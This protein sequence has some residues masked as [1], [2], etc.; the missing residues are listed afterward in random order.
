MFDPSNLHKLS[1][2]VQLSTQIQIHSSCLVKTQAWIRQILHVGKFFTLI[3]EKFTWHMG[4]E[5]PSNREK[6]IPKYSVSAKLSVIAR[7]FQKCK[8]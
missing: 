8:S 2:F 3:L 6:K 4:P 5:D 7:Q 1:F